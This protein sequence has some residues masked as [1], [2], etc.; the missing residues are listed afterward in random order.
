AFE[1]PTFR[2]LLWQ[3]GGWDYSAAK[4]WPQDPE[5]FGA[6]NLQREPE[7]EA[8]F[9]F[10]EDISKQNYK[11]STDGKNNPVASRWQ[12]A[13]EDPVRR[14]KYESISGRAAKRAFRSDWAR[15]K[16]EEVKISYSKT[17]EETRSLWKKSKYMPIGAIAIKLGGG[18]A[19]WMLASKYV[20]KT[21]NM[22]PPWII[23]D[24]MCETI[25]SLFVEQ[26]L[27]ETFATT[28]KKHEEWA[29]KEPPT[30]T[31]VPRSLAPALAEPAGAAAA[32]ATG[33]AQTG[34][35][36]APA[37][38]PPAAAPAAPEAPPAAPREPA[39]PQ[40]RKGRGA[41]GGDAKVGAV[42][43]GQPPEAKG[44]KV[45]SEA[46]E[47]MASAK[48]VITQYQAVIA[49]HQSMM[50]SIGLD[51]DWAWALE[52]DEAALK[53]MRRAKSKLD[54][55]AG[56]NVVAAKVLSAKNL[57]ELKKQIG[58]QEFMRGL[59]LVSGLTDCIQKVEE[60]LETLLGFDRAKRE[61]KRK[62]NK[63][64]QPGKAARPRKQ[65]RRGES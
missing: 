22:G 46:Q 58:D 33:A 64:E 50:M 20:W 6:S 13:L 2:N 29:K 54:D 16:H 63:Q 62:Q 31:D 52:D 27:T 4:S 45:R 65:P 49:H 15:E 25:F 19:G 26:G 28:W 21:M 42:T 23:Y 17:T 11:V 56:Q 10:W 59:A 1:T 18:K 30:L 48:K 39:A 5:A 35:A 7:D 60:E 14:Q 8:E 36:A 43:D 55:A 38:A 44:G 40:E 9:R 61:S 37:A 53:A 12:R 3:K 41:R 34:A 57:P 47:A 51:K 32:G 24:T